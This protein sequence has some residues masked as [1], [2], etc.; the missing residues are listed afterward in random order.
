VARDFQTA[1]YY[2][3]TDRMSPSLPGDEPVHAPGGNSFRFTPLACPHVLCCVGNLTRVLPFYLGHM[4]M[5]TA[6]DGLAASLHGP[7]DV[8]AKVAGGVPVKIQCRTDYPFRDT[9]QIS[10]EPE[11]PIAFPLHLRVPTW[12][13]DPL[14]TIG[15]MAQKV[16][17]NATGFI[18]IRREWARG[19]TLTLTLPMQVKVARGRET[20]Y[21]VH[22]YYVQGKR[23]A[24]NLRDIAN[25]Y[26]A[27][28]RG[29]LLFALPI[30]DRSP[31][32][33]VPDA[34]WQYAWDAAA[35]AVTLEERPMPGR[36]NWPLEAPVRLVAPAQA[37][38]WKPTNARPLPAA[39]VKGEGRETITLVPYGCAKFRVALFP[40]T[41]RFWSESDGSVPVPAS[42]R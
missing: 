17:T 8:T 21:P 31:D 12:C 9:I 7:C 20:P 28:S 27:V 29:P 41:E 42:T 2:Q 23:E 37:F 38:D 4:W 32:E 30:P 10:V 3:S 35:S 36:W 6:D 33:A 5:K 34:R 22:D 14:V 19:D 13:A 26:A 40:V 39:P 15:P 24:V 1:I 25:P 18:V 11:K 16:T